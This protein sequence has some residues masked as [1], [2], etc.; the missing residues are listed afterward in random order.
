MKFYSRYITTNFLTIF[1]FNIAVISSI[2][3]ISQS[4]RLINLFAYYNISIKD[5][6][7][8]FLLLYPAII[9]YLMPISVFIAAVYTFYN[10]YKN[11]ELTVLLS[12]GI[13]KIK[14]AKAL[15][16][17]IILIVIAH[18]ILNLYYLPL[19]NQN[20]RDEVALRKSVVFTINFTDT[21]STPFPG[22]SVYSEKNDKV[23]CKNIFI[24]DTR[25]NQKITTY[26]AAEARISS[27]NQNL[28]LINGKRQ[29]IDL[30]NLKSNTLM[31]TELEVSLGDFST[32]SNISQGKSLG[33]TSFN[34]LISSASDATDERKSKMLSEANFRILWPLLT[35]LL[36][37][38]GVN[39]ILRGEYSR[40]G[41][42]MNI[43]FYSLKV[44][45]CIIFMNSLNQYIGI[46]KLIGVGQYI[47]I[48]TASIYYLKSLR[49]SF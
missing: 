37:L 45:G 30:I 39:A 24:E 15:I 31:F 25:L 49:K 34:E 16:P 18:Y 20:F 48:I 3:V 41:K 21:F 42:K 8:I 12:A 11:S 38:L 4:L 13:S 26:N 23:S 10:L 19:A 7:Y 28:I 40:I 36:F 5:F 29:D 33:S 46:N 14:L 1:L 9:A 27:D 22:I 44:L 47:I 17:A 43:T 6:F 2:I 35:P 32:K